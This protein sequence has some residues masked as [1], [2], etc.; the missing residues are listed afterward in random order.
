MRQEQGSGR[1]AGR[2][3]QNSAALP[4]CPLSLVLTASK[5]PHALLLSELLSGA[6]STARVLRTNDKQ[7]RCR[8]CQ[9]KEQN[10]L[11]AG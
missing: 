7:V 4:G 3:R 10:S 1:G 9:A 2:G 8:T 6:D 5:E 11:T